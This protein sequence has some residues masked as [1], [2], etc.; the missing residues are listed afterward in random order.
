MQFRI[1]GRDYSSVLTEF[2]VS[3][4]ASISQ[5]HNLNKLDS[6]HNFLFIKEVQENT[7][8]QQLGV[9]GADFR[10]CCRSCVRRMKTL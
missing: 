6:L 2:F 5:P 7:L 9:Q 4:S 8:T 10:E 3:P 1:N